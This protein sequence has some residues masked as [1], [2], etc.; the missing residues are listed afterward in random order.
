[1]HWAGRQP[2]LQNCQLCFRESVPQFDRHLDLGYS[3][4]TFSRIEWTVSQRVGF[5]PK[6]DLNRSE[7]ESVLPRHT[8]QRANC[9]TT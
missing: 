8:L 2:S 9:S 4:L 5:R 3:E 7:F 1:L 6:S